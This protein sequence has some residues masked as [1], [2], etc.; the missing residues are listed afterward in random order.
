MATREEIAQELY[1]LY[2]ADLTVG[3]KA[4]VSREYNAQP[5]DEQDTTEAPEAPVREPAQATGGA[6]F[7]KCAFCRPGY[8]GERPIVA[9]AGSTM[10]DG[11]TQS[12]LSV[13]REKEGVILGNSVGGFEAGKVV[14]F[15]DT[16]VEGAEYWIMPGVDSSQ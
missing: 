5:A 14:L 2:E 12:G 7:V 4:R 11:L 13:N 9:K 8:N 1:G 15:N 10:E 6:G 3:Q 16:V